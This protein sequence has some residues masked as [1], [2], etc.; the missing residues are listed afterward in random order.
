MV[1][2]RRK[3]IRNTGAAVLFAPLLPDTF[4]AFEPE[5]TDG[6][7]RVHIFSK[8][9]QFLDFKEAG[10]IAAELGFDGLDLTVRPKGHVLPENVSSDLPSALRDI[11]HSG[12]SCIMITTAVSDTENKLDTDVIKAAA[13]EG[14]SFYRSNWFKFRGDLTMED[15]LDYYREKIRELSEYNK[16]CDIVGCYQNHSGINVGSSIWEVKKILENAD[17]AYFGAQ[18]DIRHAVAEGGKSWPNGLQL[19]RNRIKTIV[20]KD[21]KWDRINGKWE[22]VNVPVGEGMVDFTGYFRILKSYG[23]NPPAS[24]HLEYPLGGAEDGKY[25]ITIDKKVVFTAMKKDLEAVKQLWKEA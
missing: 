6:P 15:S 24:L 9:L 8:H 2:T 25:E 3:F 16:A 21:F 11:K 14:V 10:Q 22:M 1:V 18:Y 19:L 23:L 20:L 13:A 12:S 17:P 5:R 4:G 7:L